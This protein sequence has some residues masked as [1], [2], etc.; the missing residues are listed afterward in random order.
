VRTTRV[1]ATLLAIAATALLAAPAGAQANEQL[2]RFVDGQGGFCLW[3]LSD[4]E[5]APAMVPPGTLVRTAAQTD[6][7]PEILVRIT[8]DEPRFGEWIPGV[9][10]VGLHAAVASDGIAAARM[11]DG[12]PVLVTLSAVAADRPLGVDGGWLLTEIGLDAGRLDR[13]AADAWIRTDDRE[14]RVRSGLEGE[15]DQWELRFDGL[16]L[17]WQGHPGGEVRV[18]S[19]RSMSFGYA[20]NRNSVWTIEVRTAPERVQPQFGSLRVEGKSPLA[21]ALKSSPIRS[22]GALEF[23]GEMTISFRRVVQ[24]DS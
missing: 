8:Q 10:C 15:D 18:G 23:G 3:Y 2:W 11:E 16:R 1:E 21:Q 6:G 14:L 13:T 5:L 20:G 24:Q 22:V 19:T 4:P 7:L 17:F 12:P 9:I